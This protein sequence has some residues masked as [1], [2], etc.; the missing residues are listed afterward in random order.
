MTPPRFN[1]AEDRLEAR[2]EELELHLLESIWNLEEI[3]LLV[4]HDLRDLKDQ[5]V[6]A[7]PVQQKPKHP[8]V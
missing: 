4:R 5:I 3:I 2:M 7:E 6:T 8:T 1:R